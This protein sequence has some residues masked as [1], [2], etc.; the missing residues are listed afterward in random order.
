MTLLLTW[1]IASVNS[2]LMRRWSQVPKYDTA[3][4]SL[5]KHGPIHF[6]HTFNITNSQSLRH[7]DNLKR[8]IF[9]LLHF[10][11]NQVSSNCGAHVDLQND[12]ML[13]VSLWSLHIGSHWLLH[14]EQIKR[15]IKWNCDSNSPD[16]VLMASGEGHLWFPMFVLPSLLS[17]MGEGNRKRCLLLLF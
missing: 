11:Q 14:Y 2:F 9:L 5:V 12:M 16:A 6:F 4:C 17:F 13:R 1:V 8:T 7:L 3:W 15:R 10:I